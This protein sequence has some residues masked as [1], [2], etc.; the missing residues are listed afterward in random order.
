VAGV[1]EVHRGD[2]EDED[3]IEVMHEPWKLCF[4]VVIIT[5]SAIVRARAFRF[6]LHSTKTCVTLDAFFQ[7]RGLRHATVLPST[8]FFTIKITSYSAQPQPSTPTHRR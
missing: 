4:K 1:L 6:D 2:V 3:W 7:E 8:K 5:N